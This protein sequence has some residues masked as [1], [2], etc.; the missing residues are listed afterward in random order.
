MCILLCSISFIDTFGWQYIDTYF[1][2]LYRT[3]YYITNKVHTCFY[4]D[5]TMHY[6]ILRTFCVQ[7][8]LYT[9]LKP[10]IH[11]RKHFH[12]DVRIHPG[13][14]MATQVKLRCNYHSNYI[15]SHF[16]YSTCLRCCQGYKYPPE[17]ANN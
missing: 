4:A 7:A 2:I 13:L 14:F 6:D 9:I 17:A 1:Q 5:Q 8:C 3:Y 16:L 10:G 12:V 11:T 15:A